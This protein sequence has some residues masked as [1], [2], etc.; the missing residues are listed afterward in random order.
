MLFNINDEPHFPKS[1]KLISSPIEMNTLFKTGYE[2]KRRKWDKSIHKAIIITIDIH[3]TNKKF[4]VIFQQKNA[5]KLEFADNW[6]LPSLDQPQSDI[7]VFDL[8]NFHIY[9]IIAT[10]LK[11]RIVPNYIITFNEEF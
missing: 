4:S 6:W 11:H 9:N 1:I 5:C 2:K 10:K 3:Q 8:I 7:V